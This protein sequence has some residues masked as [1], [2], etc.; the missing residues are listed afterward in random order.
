MVFLL[1]IINPK[2]QLLLKKNNCMKPLFLVTTLL[3]SIVFFGQSMPEVLTF[4]EYLGYVKSYHPLVK[5][6]HLKIDEGTYK[7]M[8]A[9]GAFDP[10]IEGDFSK[11]QYSDKD[12]YQFIN[13]TIKIPTWY[14]IEV[15]AAFD[16]NE[17]IYINPENSL[18]SN[19]LTSVGVSVPI[20]KNLWINER[21]A[22]L[23][24]AKLY[25]NVT[26]A[27]QQLLVTNV[28][29][30]A[31][32]AYINWKQSFDEVK[33]YEQYLTNAKIRHD[34]VVQSIVM[35]DKPAIDS[36]ET[37]ITVKTRMLS[38]E[39]AK[40]KLVK[41]RLEL[42]NFLWLEN[43]LP[44]E[45]SENSIPQE[46]LATALQ[47]FLNLTDLEN[48]TIEN[49]PKIIALGNKFDIQKIDKK[50]QTNQ[51]LP[52]I[53]ASYNY[54][55][56]PDAF[57]DY[58]FE[59][60][61]IGVQVS[62]PLFLRKE[63]AQ[64]KL[65]DMKLQEIEY[66]LANEKLALQNKIEAQKQ[67]IK[68]LENQVKILTDL[69][70]SYAYMLTGEEKLFQAGESSVFLINSRENS[71]VKSKLETIAM[72]NSFLKAYLSLYKTLGGND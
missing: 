5:Q 26:Q 16:N 18:P 44:L 38:L 34:G 63:R 66:E 35:G 6:A 15:K 48:F 37:N 58:R 68:T 49:N 43:N 45:I 33:L 53:E 23:K 32:E 56:E 42:S 22:T 46:A 21:M 14:G 13:G 72:E 67:E 65:S 17:G 3:F 40:L 55:S 12:Y 24:Q 41:S 69:N 57:S 51:L 7:L 70:A 59:D 64:L 52:K 62:F 39:K 19:G 60:Y 29:V 25:Q 54:L 8:K 27:E 2:Q 9:R 47:A 50:L 10:K 1:I 4:E 36:T 31:S 71:L 20:G 61:K 30:S 11:K 28:L